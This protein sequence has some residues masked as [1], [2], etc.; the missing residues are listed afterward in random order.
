MVLV[1]FCEKDSRP[2]YMVNKGQSRGTSK[3]ETTK[4]ITPP[5][6]G[7]QRGD[8]EA[9]AQDEVDVPLVLPPHNF[10]LAQVRDISNTGLAPRLQDHPAYMRPPE[11]L[12]G[13]IWIEFGV[14][15]PSTLR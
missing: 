8:D 9:H 7:N 15:V 13:V 10:A 11:P 5:K 14:G 3:N 1:R 2:T 6:T 12:V 4:P